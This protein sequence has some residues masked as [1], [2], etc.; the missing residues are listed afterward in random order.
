MSMTPRYC[1]GQTPSP[2][3][4]AFVDEMASV[5]SH[6]LAETASDPFL[7]AWTDSAGENADKCA[8][9]Y[10]T[11]YDAVNEA[12]YNLV[13]KNGMQF[14]IQMNW[15]ITTGSCQLT[16]GGKVAVPSAVAI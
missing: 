4:D 2:N 16:P 13:G 11:E 14:S 10:G 9:Q 1:I 12:K 15:D 5:F 3:G 7:N 8:W 6:E